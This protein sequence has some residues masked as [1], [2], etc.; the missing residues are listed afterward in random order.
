MND[1]TDSANTK[2]TDDQLI[3]ELATII[4]GRSDLIKDMIT[5]VTLVNQAIAGLVVKQGLTND[6]LMPALDLSA[7]AINKTVE[8]YNSIADKIDEINRA[9]DS[10]KKSDEH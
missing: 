4:N 7:E 8:S 3:A 10:R 2:M 6:D 9:I 5:R 1:E